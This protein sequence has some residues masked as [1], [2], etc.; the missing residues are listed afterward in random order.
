MGNTNMLK[1]IL[2]AVDKTEHSDKCVV[3][4]AKLSALTGAPLTICTV[5]ELSGGL[6]G[7]PIYMHESTEIKSILDRAATIARANGAKSVNEVELD[8]RDV[9]G[10]VITYANQNGFDHIVTGT[11][12]KKGVSRLLLGSVA[13]HIAGS[14]GCPV[15]VVR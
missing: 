4:A 9:P 15:T 1:K 5:N 10:S 7:P 11:G 2:C 3:H 12:D 6:R 8:S 14:A 13:G